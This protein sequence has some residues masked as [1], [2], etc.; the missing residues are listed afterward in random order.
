MGALHFRDDAT[1]EGL[2]AGRTYAA[3]EVVLDLADVEWRARDKHTVEHPSGRHFFHP[4]LA[5][6]AHSC[7]PNCAIAFDPLALVARR[8]IAPG[9]AVT[10]DYEATESVISFP[11]DCLCGSPGCRGRIG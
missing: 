2:Y 5:K 4:V 9:E 3:G 7:D 11:F 10:I 8:A 6:T 1:G